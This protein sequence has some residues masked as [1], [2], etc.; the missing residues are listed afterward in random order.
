VTRLDWLILDAT[1][2]D[3]ESIVQIATHVHS[4]LPQSSRPDVARHI[5]ELLQKGFLRQLERGEISL[6]DLVSVP[7]RYSHRFGSA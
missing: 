5:I 7:E 6:E 2:D 1:A 4:D 3:F